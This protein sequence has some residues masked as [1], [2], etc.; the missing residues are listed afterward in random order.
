[1]GETW[2]ARVRKYL[3]CK[4]R[5]MFNQGRGVSFA[6]FCRRQPLAA[7]EQTRSW[8]DKNLKEHIRFQFII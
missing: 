3:L 6:F 7:P 2:R 8:G 4:L 5:Q 1:M